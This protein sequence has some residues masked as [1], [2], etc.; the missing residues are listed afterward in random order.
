M[1]DPRRLMPIISLM[2]PKTILVTGA[3]GFVG[4]RLARRLLDLG[5]RVVGHDNLNDY[6]ALEHKKR[7]L[8][9]LVASD[10]FTFVEGDLRD[11]DA[12]KEMFRRE[13]PQAVAHLAAMA[14]ARY[15]IQ[16]PLLYGTVNV[17]GSVNILDAARDLGNIPCVLSS[18]STVYGQNS[19]IPFKETAACDR[20]MAAYPASTRAMELFG[21]SYSHL[22][23]VPVTCIRF[24]NVYGPHGRP[25]MMPWQWS[26]AI[27]AGEPITLY[28][29]GQMK[30]D[31]TYI[32]DIVGGFVQALNKPFPYEILNLGCGRPIE[33]LRFVQILE[34]LV[35]KKAIIKDAPAPASEPAVTYADISKAKEL[36]GYEPRVMVEEGLKRFVEWMRAE[37]LL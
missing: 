18:T 29:G 26:R 2:D 22:Y 28:N 24:F 15:S 12:L 17:Q 20:P 33:N 5:C 31:W 30:R 13:K 3:A 19:A 14:A 6:Y 34:E 11:P 32:D 27:Q 36:L 37:K 4:S 8:R 35:G 9:D 10:R 25:D 16:H 21:F 1:V 23:G 7:H